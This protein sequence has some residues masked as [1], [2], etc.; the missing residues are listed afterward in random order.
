MPNVIVHQFEGSDVFCARCQLPR[1]NDTH[2]PDNTV[3]I[4]VTYPNGE[5]EEFRTMDLTPMEVSDGISRMLAE[6]FEPR[7]DVCNVHCEDADNWCGNCGNCMDHCEQ[8]TGCPSL[9]RDED[10]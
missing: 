7:C 10:T 4:S 9:P 6:P 5:T 3:L 2:Q 8:H 1:K